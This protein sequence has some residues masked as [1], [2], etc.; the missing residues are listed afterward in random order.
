MFK[1][2]LTIRF[3]LLVLLE[4]ALRSAYLDFSPLALQA[5]QAGFPMAPPGAHYP[6]VISLCA[7]R[8]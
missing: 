7:A 4:N 2:D 3:Y 8:R 5:S 6:G 1:P